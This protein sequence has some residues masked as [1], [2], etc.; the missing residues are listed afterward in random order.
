MPQGEGEGVGKTVK[1]VIKRVTY[2]SV[3]YLP[4]RNVYQRVVNRSVWRY[5]RELRRFYSQFVSRGDLVFD[6]GANVGFYTDVF[7]GLG[8]RVVAVE[9]TPECVRV[10]RSQRV[11]RRL[12]V[13]AAALGSVETEAPFFIC[14][15]SSARSTLSSAWLDVARSVPR[16]AG[17]SWRDELTVHVT[18]LD[19]L[20]AKYG[21]PA[22]MRI[23]VEGHEEEVL[24]GLARLPRCLSFDFIR[25]FL[26][27]A[28]ECV[29]K[30]C[31]PSRARFN[32]LVAPKSGEAPASLNFALGKWVSGDELVDILNSA[33]LRHGQTYGEIFARNQR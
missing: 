9:P 15:G 31:F 1:E 16:L 8:A 28:V 11:G 24:A 23:D 6:V 18:T 30:K 21:E 4:L 7:L 3:V 26:D 20:V 25:E 10:L 32:L 19:R 27:A 13:E 12:R 2:T 5:R 22:F 33:A 29:Y 17:K 14:D